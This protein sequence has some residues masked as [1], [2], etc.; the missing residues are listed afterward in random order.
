MEHTEG[1]P[2]KVPKSAKI[3]VIRSLVPKE[4]E[5]DLI[6]IHPTADCKTTKT[7]IL[8]Q[9]ALR[10]D[11][12]FSDGGKHGGP[13]PMEVDQLLAKIQ[14]LKEG[15]SGHGGS[16]DHGSEPHSGGEGH[17]CHDHQHQDDHG[18][19]QQATFAHLEKELMALKGQKG[20]AKGVPRE[21]RDPD[22]RAIATIAGPGNIV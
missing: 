8:E 7:Y 15:T 12:H 6:K 17:S 19:D 14:E 3:F 10:K 20:E 1:E 13:A 16:E 22:S 21:A 5:K 18:N 4:L 11:A 2:H 9:A